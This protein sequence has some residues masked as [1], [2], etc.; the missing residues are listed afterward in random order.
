VRPSNEIGRGLDELARAL[1]PTRGPLGVLLEKRQA[2]TDASAKAEI[3]KQLLVDDAREWRDVVAATPSLAGLN[4]WAER[5]WNSQRGAAQAQ[6]VAADALVEISSDH[7]ILSSLGATQK[8]LEEIKRGAI[9]NPDLDSDYLAG[10]GAQWDDFTAQALQKSANAQIDERGRRSAAVIGENV[11]SALELAWR[12]GDYSRAFGVLDASLRSS[13]ALAFDP[14]LVEAGIVNSVGGFLA[15]HPDLAEDVIPMFVG[16]KT[17]YVTDPGNVARLKDMRNTAA[18]NLYT[19]ELRENA[20]FDRAQRK[21]RED[22]LRDAGKEAMRGEVSEETRSRLAEEGLVDDFARISASIESQPFL[23]ENEELRSVYEREVREGPL[24]TDMPAVLHKAAINGLI[25]WDTK[26]GLVAIWDSRQGQGTQGTPSFR[27]AHSQLDTFLR[28]REY[29]PLVR[30]D[31]LSRLDTELT[32]WAA[33]NPEK[34]ANELGLQAGAQ[35][36]MRKVRDEVIAKDEAVATPAQKRAE[37]QRKEQA[38]IRDADEQ[39][40]LAEDDL[41][42]AN[43]AIVAFWQNSTLTSDLQTGEGGPAKALLKA[44]MDRKERIEEQLYGSKGLG[45][46]RRDGGLVGLR[47]DVVSGSSAGELQRLT[48]ENPEYINFFQGKAAFL[49]EE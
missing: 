17:P 12:T 22:L 14:K 38:L 18:S 10:F 25:K 21:R 27:A 42:K 37:N 28:E 13:R 44:L 46:L 6:R 2:E 33:D 16:G 23:I 45:F 26:D 15:E 30:Q 43:E 41:A 20:I 29:E 3:E 24:D 11:T 48:D 47:R 34:A 9:A 39:I 7:E 5:F 4:P 31:A 19:Q 36:V 35:T 49:A 32:Q 8:R 1:D 40:A